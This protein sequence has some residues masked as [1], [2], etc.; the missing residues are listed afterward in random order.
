M[1]GFEEAVP[2]LE[3]SLEARQA[4]EEGGLEL[5]RS[6]GARE[7]GRTERGLFE[8]GLLAL[9]LPLEA[10]RCWCLKAWTGVW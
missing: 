9:L 6:K 10:A 1:P 2:G 3:S 7:F 8:L 5:G 4:C